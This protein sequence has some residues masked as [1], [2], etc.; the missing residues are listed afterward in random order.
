MNKLMLPIFL[1]LLYFYYWHPPKTH[2]T[3]ILINMYRQLLHSHFI[4]YIFS[5]L[6][7]TLPSIMNNQQKKNDF[8]DVG[9]S[10]ERIR[11][12]WTGLCEGRVKVHLVDE[13]L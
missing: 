13:L 1:L 10:K 2:H 11:S 3:L 4:L 6:A 8:N 12:F 9:F 5:F 7:M